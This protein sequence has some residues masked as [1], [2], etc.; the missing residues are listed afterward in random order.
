MNQ[1]HLSYLASPEWAQAL[2]SD[3]LPWLESIGDLGD[4]V[5][6]I[7]PGPGLTTDLLREKSAAVTAVEI[8][9]ELASSLTSRLAGTNVTVIEGD[10]NVVGMPSDHFTTA[11]CFSMLHH[12]PT[13]ADQDELFATMCR[14]LRPGGQ[15]VGIDSLDTERI[16]QAHV[17]DVFV[18]LDQ[19]TL[20]SRLQAAGFT[21]IVVERAGTYAERGDQ[22][23]FY[24]KKPSHN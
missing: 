7:G 18:P 20:V 4:A 16:R 2:R 14:V 12:M 21:H 8:D 5:I 13:P 17:D 23:R 9:P 15:L 22:V 6:E 24:A 19:D 10:A 11:T 3:L 1:A